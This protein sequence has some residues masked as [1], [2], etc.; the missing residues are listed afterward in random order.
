MPKHAAEALYER[1]LDAWNARDPRAYANEFSAE[2]SLVG[3][4]G[5]S[6]ETP[7]EIFQHLS[8]V[9]DDHTPA[10]Y[11]AVVRDVR[12]LGHGAALLRADAGMVPPDGSEV[13]EEL[14]TIHL[15]VALEENGTWQVAHFQSTPA[16]WHGRDDDRAALTGELQGLV[17]VDS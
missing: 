5:S 6:V 10:T 14:N 11:D 1:L 16:A 2:G 7:S 12:P 9:F 8:S 17:T 13:K 4:D 3:F 15:L